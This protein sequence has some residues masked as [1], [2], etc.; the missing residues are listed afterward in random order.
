MILLCGLD[1]LPSNLDAPERLV[2]KAFESAGRE[3]NRVCAAARALVDDFG[4]NGLPLDYVSKIM[5]INPS[6]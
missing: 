4:R 6:T 2:R 1:E 3:V 5:I